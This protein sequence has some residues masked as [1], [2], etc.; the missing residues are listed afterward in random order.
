MWGF[1][2]GIGDVKSIMT[3]EKWVEQINREYLAAGANLASEF[4]T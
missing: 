2:L 1:G 3:T 4:T